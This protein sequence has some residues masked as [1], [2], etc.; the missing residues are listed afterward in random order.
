MWSRYVNTDEEAT[1][2]NASIANK[3][4]RVVSL[5]TKRAQE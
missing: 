1:K 2:T 3:D 4:A 5:Q